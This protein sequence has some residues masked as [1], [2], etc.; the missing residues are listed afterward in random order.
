MLKKL[1]TI[2]AVS[3]LALMA[4]YNAGPARAAEQS[5]EVMHWWTSAGEAA[6]LNV[7]KK[8]LESQ[9]IQWRDA[10]VAGGGGDAAMT[11]LRARVAAGDPPTA[12]QLLGLPVHDWAESG[13]LLDLTSVAEKE[14][15]AKELPPQLQFFSTYKGKYVAAPINMHRVNWVWINKALL[16][17]VGGKP[18]ATF[19]E[20]LDLASK[21]KQAGITPLA[22]GGQAWQEA[23]IFDSAVLSVG[24]PDFYRKALVDLDPKALGG[25]TMQKAF[26]QL[27]KLRGLVDTNFTNRDWNLASAMVVN[28]Q[29]GMQIMGDWAKG[30]FIRAGLTPGKEIVCV[31][32]PG[33][34]NAFIFNSDQLAMFKANKDKQEIGIKLAEAVMDPA[35]QEEFNAIKGSLPARLDVPVTRLDP[36]GQKAAEDRQQAITADSLVPSMAHGHAGG[37]AVKGA[38]YDVVTNFFNSNM[39]SA[40]AAEQLVEAVA[41]AQ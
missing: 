26:D 38:Y 25:D 9:G 1:L 19:D 4:G 12:V 5:V 37:A 34:A 30:E 21:F 23:T 8:K 14:G 39:S 27:R 20:L 15:W 7:L 18:P 13:T 40:D 24:G 2:T 10:P 41:N 29:A 33:T 6:A 17:K 3:A 31:P 32:Y 22:H 28:G 16:D 35:V 11:A 36:C